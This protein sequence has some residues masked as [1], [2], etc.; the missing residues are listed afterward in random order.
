VALTPHVVLHILCGAEA[1]RFAER[2]RALVE[3]ASVVITR[4]KKIDSFF[5]DEIDD[6]MLL[7]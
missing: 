4:L 7:R 1:K 6:S 3:A 5:A 2:K